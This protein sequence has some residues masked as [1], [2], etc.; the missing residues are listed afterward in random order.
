M[1]EEARSIIK[2][3][4]SNIPETAYG[5]ERQMLIGDLASRQSTEERVIIKRMLDGFLMRMF[6]IMASDI[7]I[8][9]FGC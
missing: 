3:I 6:E 5:V 1:F 7:D 9:G 8:G 4:V 2:Q